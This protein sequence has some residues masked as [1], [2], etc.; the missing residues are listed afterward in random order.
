M[1]KA[2]AKGKRQNAK[3]KGKGSTTIVN[4]HRPFAIPLLKGKYVAEKRAA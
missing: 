1:A 3:D 4:S 2:K